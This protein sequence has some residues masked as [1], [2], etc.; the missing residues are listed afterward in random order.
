[1]AVEYVNRQGQ[2]Y[3]LLQGTTKMGKPQLYFAMKPK[4]QLADAIPEGYEIYEEPE[5]A[6]VFLRKKRPRKITEL[7]QALLEECIR[8]RAKVSCFIVDA[9]R[10]SLI[11][12]LADLEEAEAAEDVHELARF[13]TAERR[14]QLVEERMLHGHFTKVL[15]FRLVD[16]RKRFFSV[17]RWCFRGSIDDWI[18]L[19]DGGTLHAVAE[20]YVPH[21]GQASFF[22]LS[23][24]GRLVR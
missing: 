11:V 13:L 5:D 24:G 23:W 10:D 17:E 19:D 12:Y 4:G 8:R 2:V 21:L 14:A 16:V 15:R 22:E 18:P 3:Y 9:D 7:E 20:K 1:M 6:Q